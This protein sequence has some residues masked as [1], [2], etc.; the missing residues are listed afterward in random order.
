M[1]L[2]PPRMIAGPTASESLGCFLKLQIPGTH[3]KYE[4]QVWSGYRN[5]FEPLSLMILSSLK[6]RESWV[7]VCRA[8]KLCTTNL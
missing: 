1:T 2:S 4:S 3:L 7:K 6:S 5:L 8:E